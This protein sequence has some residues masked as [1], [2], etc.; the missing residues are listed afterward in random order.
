MRASVGQAVRTC[1]ACAMNEP[2]VEFFREPTKN[3]LLPKPL[4]MIAGLRK[5]GPDRAGPKPSP[6]FKIV[7]VSRV[8]APKYLAP[9]LPPDHSRV[10]GSQLSG[11]WM[12]RRDAV[13]QT[14]RCDSG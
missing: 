12:K 6:N 13:C 9:S 2:I 4:K 10:R 1:L 11:R 5:G 3:E 8:R 7:R 14:W